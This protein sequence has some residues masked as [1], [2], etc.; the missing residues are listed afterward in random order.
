MG[1]T[2]GISQRTNK[3]FLLSANFS[4]APVLNQSVGHIAKR[5]LDSLLIL[6]KRVRALS[7]FKID[8]RLKSTSSKDRLCDLGNE[9]PGAT[10]A[11]EQIRQRIA[12]KSKAA[13]E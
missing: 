3:Q 1:Q 9:S 13:R 11:A 5:R 4:D 6:R 10:R 7:L 8:I 12:L 2:R